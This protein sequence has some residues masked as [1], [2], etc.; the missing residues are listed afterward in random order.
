MGASRG[1]ALVGQCPGRSP[2]FIERRNCGG[3][4]PEESTAACHRIVGVRAGNTISGVIGNV[5]FAAILL[6]GSMADDPKK[7]ASPD[8]KRISLSEPHE[9]R[10]WTKKL[11]V[12]Q[13]RLRSA[14]NSVG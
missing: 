4:R 14:V 7:R 13:T 2:R 5:A 8:N 6:G 12:T 9:V 3:V 10:Y 1:A 11:G